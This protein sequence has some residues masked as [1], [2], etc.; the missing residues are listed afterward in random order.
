MN[1]LVNR[2]NQLESRFERL[3]VQVQALTAGVASVAQQ[4]G[5]IQNQ[6]GGVGSSGGSNVLFIDPVVISAG[7]NVTGQTLYWNI[8]GTLTSTGIT[9]AVVYNMM[10]SA[11]V[12]TSGK[13]IIVGP[14]IDGTYSVITQSC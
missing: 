14:N 7:G 9:T 2:L 8:G 5:Q 6:Q 3:V 12:L 4:I 11:T 10:A 13:Y 1:G